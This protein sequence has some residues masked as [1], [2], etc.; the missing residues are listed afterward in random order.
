MQGTLVM[1][2]RD[3]KQP[4][5]TAQ[6]AERASLVDKARTAAL[7][8]TSLK[9]QRPLSVCC[10]AGS[11]AA[12]EI[13]HGNKGSGQQKTNNRLLVDKGAIPVRCSCN[14]S[15]SDACARSSQPCARHAC[16]AGPELAM[17]C[18]GRGGL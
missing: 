13:T 12:S 1:G 9:R 15:P 16:N 3:D 4:M 17:D 5:R 11:G 10:G 8:R 7:T 6:D 2:G 14:F 18:A